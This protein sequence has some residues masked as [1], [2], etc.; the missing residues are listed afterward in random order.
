MRHVIAASLAVVAAALAA[1]SFA[2]PTEIWSTQGRIED[3]DSQDADQFRYDD[4]LIRLEAGRR[5]RIHAASEDFDT[6]LQLYRAG[7]SDPLA[8]NDDYEGLNSR[9]SFT[10]EEAGEYRVRVRSYSPEG[11]GAYTASAEAMPP[12]PAPVSTPDSTVDSSGS[13]ALWQR[14]LASTD[15]DLEGRHFDDYL[16]TMAAGQT[17]WIS[18]DSTVIDPMVAI[19][20][21]S[22]PEADPIDL[23]D[24][25]GPGVNA[26][27]GFQAEE[28]GS[29]IVR[30]TSY[31]QGETGAYRLWVSR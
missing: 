17:R 7:G 19:L 9:I 27:L 31:G 21:G 6:Y 4:H 12:L 2:Q 24:D 5:Y 14:D 20:P 10:P 11:R 22:D 23:D 26:L 15:P 25:A 28:A 3:S 18:V 13:W 16:I 30:V 29:Y 1:P 8:E